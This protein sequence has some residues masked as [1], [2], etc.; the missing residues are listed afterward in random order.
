MRSSLRKLGESLQRLPPHMRFL[1]LHLVLG[2]AIGIGF[3]SFL[4]LF[5][6][7]GLKDLVTEA[8]DPVLPL[9]LLYCFN[10]FTFSSV[11]MGIAVMTLP[12]R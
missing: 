5:N 9:L 11:S 12:K 1:G 8:D 10:V 4:V 2:A 7:A 3:V 6:L